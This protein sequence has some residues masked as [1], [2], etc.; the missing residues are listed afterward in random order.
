MRRTLSR[1]G[2]GEHHGWT[3]HGRQE[4]RPHIGHPIQAVE[5]PSEIKY[6]KPFIYDNPMPPNGRTHPKCA[7]GGFA[8]PRRPGVGVSGKLNS[9]DSET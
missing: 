3:R 5:A 1:K 9:V 7:W 6:T 4:H 2:G 8:T